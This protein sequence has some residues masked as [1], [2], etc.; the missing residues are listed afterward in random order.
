M[1]NWRALLREAVRLEASGA[2]D[3]WIELLA[4]SL[5]QKQVRI[6][7]PAYASHALRYPREQADFGP[8]RARA[9]S[10]ADDLGP[11]RAQAC[12]RHL[13]LVPRRVIVLHIAE[14]KDDAMPRRLSLV[15]AMAMGTEVM[16]AIATL[17]L[18]QAPGKFGRVVITDFHIELISGKATAELSNVAERLYMEA[19]PAARSWTQGEEPQ[20][21]PILW[22]GGSRH[23]VQDLDSAWRLRIEAVA[24]ARG[25]QAEIIEQPYAHVP[26]IIV[27]A[28]ALRPSAVVVW[29]PFSRGAHADLRLAKYTAISVDEEEFEGAL[30][31]TRSQLDALVDSDDQL[32]QAEEE[33]PLPFRPSTWREFHDKLPQ[34]ESEAFVLTDNARNQCLSNPYPDP[35]R[36]WDH[37]ERLSRAANE[38]A[39][40][41]CVVNRGL[42]VW[43]RESFA[44]EVA[45]FDNG[46]GSLGGFEYEGKLRSR[47]PHVKVD[48]Y[49]SPAECGRIHFAY[50]STE[51]RFIVDH[52]GLHL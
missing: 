13:L 22:L 7:G 48:D 9:Q 34:L 26:D 46:L 31:A 19:E 10:L 3:G 27:R 43:I 17:E 15:S 28:G 2:P 37:L 50:D 49:K 12:L 11:G 8:V 25:F 24:R 33:E 1:F 6:P 44:I 5:R 41:N 51:R 36:M 42:R 35:A 39:V 21:E 45:L 4:N 40:K 14:R 18:L 20:P 23:E 29:T 38:W 32:V 52:I 47:Q 30:I 16:V